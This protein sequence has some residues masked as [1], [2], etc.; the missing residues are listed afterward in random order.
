MSFARYFLEQLEVAGTCQSMNENKQ[1]KQLK[2][3]A[4]DSLNSATTQDAEIQ[5]TLFLV[6]VLPLTTW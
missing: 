6:L 2:L 1:T 3:G 4:V 5:S